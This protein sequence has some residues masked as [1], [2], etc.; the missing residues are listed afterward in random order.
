MTN[1]SGR[2]RILSDLRRLSI[3]DVPLP[4]V[5]G[6]WV[7]Y[8]DLIEQLQQMVVTVG[9]QFC[10]A[11]NI[12]EA[13]A[14]LEQYPAWRE[15]SRR[16]LL[17]LAPNS[18][19]EEV[20][21]QL[22]STWHELDVLVAPG[23]FAVAENAAIWVDERSIGQRS[24]LFLTRHLVLV[25]PTS[26]VVANMHEAYERLAKDQ[27][28]YGCFVSGPSKTADIEQSLVIGAHGPRSLLVLL[29]DSP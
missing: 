1:P 20:A 24:I 15:S 27:P 7:S 29:V 22:P 3:P 26:C 21:Q 25:V 2:Q 4:S 18:S 10:R 12:S 16:V 17:A 11:R 28:R 5:I 9:G 23:Q 6:P 14:H 13:L 8:P 19:A